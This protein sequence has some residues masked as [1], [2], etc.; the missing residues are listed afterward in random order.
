[1]RN[2]RNISK[3]KII[4]FLGYYPF[5]ASDTFSCMLTKYRY[6]NGL[7]Y[8]Q[9]GKL[10]SVDGSTVASWEAQRTV[11]NRSTTDYVLTTL[12]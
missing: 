7:T 11:P 6:T 8:K 9:V 5:K 10:L 2:L 4:F 1:M 12:L 3:N